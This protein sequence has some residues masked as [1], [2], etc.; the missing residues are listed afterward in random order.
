MKIHDLYD[1]ISQFEQQVTPSTRELSSCRRGCSK[2]CYTDISVFEVEANN[3]RSWFHSLAAAKKA[4]LSKLWSAPALKTMS[5]SGEEV[6]SCVFLNQE[7]CSIYEAR[8]LICRTQGHAL[9]FRE[10]KDMFVDICPLNEE[11]LDTLTSSEMIN[12]DLLNSILSGLEKIDSKNTERHRIRLKD[13][14]DE[15]WT[16]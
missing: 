3:I 16:L 9:S 11:M 10:G 2:C 6:S 4:E 12:L 1:K 13:L 14:K 8:P 7:S 15:L 5:F